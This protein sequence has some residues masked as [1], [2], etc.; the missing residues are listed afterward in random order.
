MAKQ[1]KDR[2]FVHRFPGKMLFDRQVFEPLSMNQTA[3]S[4]WYTKMI[5]TPAQKRSRSERDSVTRFFSLGFFH[6]SSPANP[7]KIIFL[8]S[9][10]FINLR[11]NSQVRV[12]HRY[13]RCRWYRW[14]VMWQYQTAYTLKWTCR[15]K[16]YLYV[17][18]TTQ[19][20]PNNSK[21]FLNEDFFICHRL[22]HLELRIS[23]RIIRKNWKGPTG[24]SGAWGKLIHEKKN[25]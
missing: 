21:T 13:R 20:C 5:Q 7:L 22:V 14:Q 17:N 3:G 6:E 25:L 1:R 8:I 12:Q 10:L 24:Y 18:P 16:M 11:R 2:T 19:R 4:T 9:N 15:E 23:P